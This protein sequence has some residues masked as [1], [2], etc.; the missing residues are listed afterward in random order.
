MAQCM[1]NNT[2]K[3]LNHNNHIVHMY[4]NVI[5]V[6]MRNIHSIHVYTKTVHDLKNKFLSLAMYL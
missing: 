5:Q 4:T 6:H 2:N 3:R 1:A